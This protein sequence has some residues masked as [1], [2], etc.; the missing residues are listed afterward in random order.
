MKAPQSG[1]SAFL[2]SISTA[3]NSPTIVCTCILFLS[4]LQILFFQFPLSAF[5]S[6]FS[7]CTTCGF[8]RG[9]NSSSLPIITERNAPASFAVRVC[10]LHHRHT[11]S[12]PPWLSLLFLSLPASLP[13]SIS[14][15]LTLFLNFNIH[16]Y[17]IHTKT[18]L[19][20]LICFYYAVFPH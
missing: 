3:T 16:L 17:F 10:P 14:P 12:F 4:F 18:T 5:F 15:S 1:D 7:L 11:A 9:T 19:G 8:N 6:F 13:L 2:P 20:C